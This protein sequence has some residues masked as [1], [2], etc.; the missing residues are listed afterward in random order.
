MYC[1]P[2]SVAVRGKPGKSGHRVVTRMG[3][4]KPNT[5]TMTPQELAGLAHGA[6]L[7]DPAA[8]GEGV[9]EARKL[10]GGALGYYYRYLSSSGQRQRI[11]IATGKHDDGSLKRARADAAALRARY[12]SGDKDLRDILSA[13]QTEATRLR[14]TAAKAAEI[15][16][17]KAESTLGVL[18]EAYVANMR[19]AG[20][21]SADS[22]LSCVHRHVRDAKPKLWKM[23]VADVTTDN[24]MGAVAKLADADK[25][26]EAAKLRSYLRAA[27][28]AGIRARHTAKAIPALRALRIAHNPAVDLAPIEGSNQARDRALSV[29]ELRQYWNRIERLESPDGP[30]LRFHMLTGCQRIEQLARVTS[31]DAQDGDRIRI[32]DTKGRRRAPRMHYVP[33][34]P[35]AVE[36]MQA[37]EGGQFGEFLFTVTQGHSGVSYAIIQN[38]VRVVA[39][40]MLIAGELPGGMFTTGDL[41][42]TVETRL[43]AE[44]VSKD[45][46]AQLQSHGLGGV[47]DRHYDQHDYLDAKRGALDT[48]FRVLTNQSATVTPIRK[49]SRASQ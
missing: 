40:E 42:R 39:N 20:K 15:E 19:K 4:S 21:T 11:L 5:G 37:M 49:K 43:A 29:A 17:V 2:V 3:K 33:L 46:R 47:Q 12:Q 44:G 48:L 23:P 22:V 27:F 13:E 26:R 9:F 10:K 28:A 45:I 7:A 31:S 38:R 30:L 35:A 36:A 6:W 32:R 8:R 16:K 24:L 1:P 14:A 25:L 34:I 41:R 18:L